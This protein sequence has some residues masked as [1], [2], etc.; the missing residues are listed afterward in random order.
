[1][2]RASAFEKKCRG[3]QITTT[4]FMGKA[5]GMIAFLI[6]ALIVARTAANEIINCKT[7]HDRYTA[8]ET[9]TKTG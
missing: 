6:V 4:K 2:W 3:I 8:F 7:K 5:D 9:P 1:M